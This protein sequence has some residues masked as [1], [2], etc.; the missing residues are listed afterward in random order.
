MPNGKYLA[1]NCYNQRSF[2]EFG[3]WS[4]G[5]ANFNIHGYANYIMHIAHKVRFIYSL[6]KITTRESTYNLI[7]SVIEW[8]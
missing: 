5:Y 6:D 8:W 1:E 7:Y 4:D 3:N 2:R